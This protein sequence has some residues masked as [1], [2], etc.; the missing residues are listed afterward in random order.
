MT[1]KTIK[2]KKQKTIAGYVAK[3][4]AMFC[5]TAVMLICVNTLNVKAEL[6]TYCVPVA[7]VSAAL[8]AYL[9]KQQKTAVIASIKAKSVPTVEAVTANEQA[10]DYI[11]KNYTNLGIA[12]VNTTLNVR[13]SP[14]NGKVIGRIPAGGACEVLETAE[15]W[16]KVKSGDVEGYVSANYLLTGDLA[17]ERA[18]K[19]LSETATVN[20]AGLNMR[21]SASTSAKVITVLKRNTVVN[22]LEDL[23]EWLKIS[24]N[25]TTGYVYS[26][27]TELE[28]Q[29]PEAITVDEIKYGTEVSDLRERVV[30]YAKQFVGN[31]YVYGGNSLTHGT[32]CSGFVK[33]IMAHFGITT[34]RTAT[35]QYNAGRKIS[36]AELLP[37][38]L[39]V[40]GDRQIE[41]IA[42]YIGDG[43]VVHASNAKTG[44]KY[45]KYNYRNIYGC[46]RFI[47]N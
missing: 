29:L 25:N 47:E 42:I 6:Y 26:K 31:P 37:G 11:R 43:Q 40:Y 20:V 2:V 17:I 33:L 19:E 13:V 44:I 7:G 15:G 41:H 23:G 32:D 1:I 38:D 12:N 46:V 5:T 8:D 10:V 18:A 14:V 24:Y 4:T 34:P 30:A 3:S 9:E 27:Y 45:S 21:K 22:V 35:T 28:Y 36:V 39:I 16:F